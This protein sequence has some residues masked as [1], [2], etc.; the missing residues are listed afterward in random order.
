MCRIATD[1]TAGLHLSPAGYEILFQELMKVVGE[2]WPDQS[3]DKLP[4]VLPPWNDA[5]AWTAWE[6]QYAGAE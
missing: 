2:R 6:K 4:M 1:T 3:P 5:E